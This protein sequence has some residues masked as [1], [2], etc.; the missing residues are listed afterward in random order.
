M[1]TEAIATPDTAPPVIAPAPKQQV[2]NFIPVEKAVPI[3]ITPK[4]DLQMFQA[5]LYQGTLIMSALAL[6]VTLFATRSAG[7]SLLSSIFYA[8]FA[9]TATGIV[10]TLLTHWLI[11]QAFDAHKAA[12]DPNES[13]EFNEK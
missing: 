9:A 12:K 13:Q 2:K 5:W 4:L 8:C 11:A 3:P 6:V 10:S 7:R 1:A